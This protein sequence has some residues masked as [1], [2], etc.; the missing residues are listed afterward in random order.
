MPFFLIHFLLINPFSWRAIH[1]NSI[2]THFV[3]SMGSIIQPE[4]ASL[5]WA[6]LYVA[7][8]FLPIWWM[9]RRKIFIK[10]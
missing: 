9:Y 8:C 2:Q 7:F 5:S 10:I 6:F 1:G 3:D 4:L